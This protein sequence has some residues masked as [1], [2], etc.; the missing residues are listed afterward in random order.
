MA[1]DLFSLHRPRTDVLVLC[2]HAISE[3]WDSPLAVTPDDLE[4]QVGFLLNHGYV[5]ATFAQALTAPPASHTLVVTFDDAYASV[6]DLAAPIL[7]RA[8]VPAT[9][10]VPTQLVDLPG[11][12]SWPGIEHWVGTPHEDELLPMGWD[13]VAQLAEAGWEI[14]AHTRTHPHLTQLDDAT[15]DAELRGSREEVEERL[16]RP[17]PSIAYPFGDVDQRVMAAADAA[18]LRFGALLPNSRDPWPAALPLGWPRIGVYPGTGHAAFARETSFA[19]RR[20]RASAVLGP[21]IK[22]GKVK[23]QLRRLRRAT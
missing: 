17:C 22:A 20:L 16:G 8:S 15:L 23:S 11:P 7:A 12:M 19:L 18:G 2:Y 10:F 3:G 1:P 9:L 14:G 5:G 6:L 13:G 4:Q 21:A